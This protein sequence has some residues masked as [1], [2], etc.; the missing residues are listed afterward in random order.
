MKYDCSIVL[1]SKNRKGLIKA[2]IDSI[3]NNGF[4]GTLEIIVVDGGSTDGTC[5]WLAKQTDVFTIIQ[6]NY[7]IVAEDGVKKRAHSWGEFMNIG[8]KHA[9]SDYICMISD[10]LILAPGCLQKGYDEIRH[11]I[12]VGEKIGGGAFFFRE[13]PRHD[14]YRV[15][16]LAE[17]NVHINHGIYYR[18]AMVDINWLDETNYSFYCADGDFTM[19]LNRAGWKTIA[20]KD[21]FAAHLVHAPKSKKSIPQ[22]QLNDLATYHKMYPETVANPI[23]KHEQLPDINTRAFWRYALKNV[24]L[25][26]VLKYIDK[27]EKYGGGV[28]KRL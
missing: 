5:D 22:W 27:Y 14:Y 18:P 28:L 20:L 24:I 4:D 25:G 13:Y 17:N 3:R 2:T 11:R 15:I 10:D 7:S 19:R 16:M 6:P 9:H 12:E 8:F 26:F 21:C 23:L 1:G